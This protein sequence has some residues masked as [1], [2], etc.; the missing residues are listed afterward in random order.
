MLERLQRAAGWLRPALPVAVLGGL[1]GVALFL[2]S[3]VAGGGGQHDGW[4]ILGLIAALWGA[5]LFALITA[6][7]QLPAPADPQQGFVQRL[8]AR[9]GRALY[10]AVA[11]LM[12]TAAAVSLL[13]TYRLLS[14]W[15]S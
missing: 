8:K 3:A 1:A 2:W 13:M 15:I 5:L 4:M 9:V 12:L 11:W 14:L 6:F 10:V 7:R